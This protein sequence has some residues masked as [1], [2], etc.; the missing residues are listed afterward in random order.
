M[1]RWRFALVVVTLV[2]GIFAGHSAFAQS[3]AG[4]GAGNQDSTCLGRVTAAPQT[5]PACSTA[6]GWTTVAPAQ[7][8]GSQYS[9]PQCN[10]QAPPP[11]CPDGDTT[12][13][14]AS[15]NGSEWIGPTCAAPPPPSCPSGFQCA[16][17]GNPYAYLIGYCGETK[18]RTILHV[19]QYWFSCTPSMAGAVRV[20]QEGNL[21]NGNG[22]TDYWN[23]PSS[24]IK[25]IYEAW[26]NNAPYENA[27]GPAGTVVQSVSILWGNIIWSPGDSGSTANSFFEGQ[28]GN[29]SNEGW[30]L[31]C[32]AAHPTINFSTVAAYGE[33]N[34][35]LIECQ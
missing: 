8:I 6:A 33:S 15:W 9:A 13:S 1:R 21:Y 18:Q 10:Y 20:I 31:A 32:P 27:P 17:D 7:W 26:T 12:T 24:F 16:A 22:T 28:A 14:P 30:T 5:P 11:P 25:T 23:T 4:C 34:P 19:T 35:A 2:T 29:G 3:A